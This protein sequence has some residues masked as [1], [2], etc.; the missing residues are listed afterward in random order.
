VKTL[1]LQYLPFLAAA[2]VLKGLRIDI[3]APG[4]S[5]LGFLD[6]LVPE[7]GVHAIWVGS[8]GLVLSWL[9]AE[10]R[11]A[12]VLAHAVLSAGAFL[13]IGLELVAVTF[14]LETGG[15]LDHHLFSFALVNLIAVLP[16]IQ[17]EV[18]A[19]QLLSAGIFLAA[20]VAAR[21]W[22]IARR[23]VGVPR[24]RSC[25]A[26]VA[27]GALAL[28]SLPVLLPRAVG[29]PL[30]L[31]LASGPLFDPVRVAPAPSLERPPYT[32]EGR[33][34]PRG[35]GAVY[36]H[37]VVVALE[38][39]GLFAT[40]LAEGGPDTTP[41]LARLA[42]ESAVFERAYV[43]VPHSSKAVVALNCGI[44]PLLLMEVRESDPDGVPVRCLP[45]LLREQ[46]FQTLY[47]GSHVGGFEYW[48][49]L[50]RNLG[51]AV[52]ITVEQLDRE[53]FEAVNYFA[54]EDD[55]LLE[56]TREW[57]ARTAGRKVYSFYLTSTAHHDYDVP[58]RYP[59]RDFARDDRHDRY[60]NAVYYQDRFLE[61]LVAL[62]RDAGLY[63]R[64][65]FVVVGDHGEA[66]GEH[67]RKLHDHVIYDEVIR[68]PLLIHGTGVEP[69]RHEAVVGQ[70]D[71]AP[72]L[73]GLLGY[74][75]AG[76]GYDGRS[77]FLRGPEALTRVSCFYTERCLAL[78]SP[79]RKLISHFDHAPPEAYAIDVD[80]RETE[81]LFGRDP[82]DEDGLRALHAWKREQLGRFLE[83][84]RRQRLAGRD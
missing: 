58:S 10:R 7:I 38:S 44:T 33:L 65:L 51:F 71:L 69:G 34:V 1:F 82:G 53:G 12:G 77:L 75:L 28:A 81:N 48:R 31:D 60:L 68:I 20:V 50:M 40:S 74:D 45:D 42:R 46:G 5:P 76:A 27:V 55:I 14:A 84:R 56:P 11:F 70:V 18:P 61:K 43:A 67:D 9:G 19:S 63:E 52:T 41:F 62:Y 72:T 57:L 36:D 30:P 21:T 79:G 2:L 26:V 64:T 15:S 25:A 47:F 66:F 73:A 32:R 49:R 16:V 4:T 3:L 59:R 17:S 8:V 6:A 23:P 35:N 80:P 39:T 29:V 22:Q 54:Y 83:G 37:V 24:P 13:L 78:V